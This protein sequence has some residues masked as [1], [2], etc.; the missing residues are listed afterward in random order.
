MVSKAAKGEMRMTD[1]EKIT[2][3][4][5][6]H[7]KKVQTTNAVACMEC[8]YAEPKPIREWCMSGL[9]DDIYTL[10]KEQKR[11]DPPRCE[12]CRHWEPETGEEGAGDYGRCRH[13]F[14]VCKGEMTGARWYCGDWE[15]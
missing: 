11:P 13:P 15:G 10:M 2:K 14:G 9:M 3:G 6:C 8:P 4:V 7:R 5:E 1:R 12:A